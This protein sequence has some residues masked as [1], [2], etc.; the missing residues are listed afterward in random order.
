MM[1]LGLGLYRDLLTPETLRF[2]RQA[3]V[4]HIVA[5]LPGHFT[6]GADDVLTSDQ[7]GWGFGISDPDDPMWTFEALEALKRTVNDA[8]LVLE[9]LENFAPAHWYDVLLDGPRRAEQMEHLKTIVGALGRAGIPTMGYNF[10]LAGVWGRVEGPFA[11]AGA[12][13]VGFQDPVQPPIPSGMIWNMV[14]AP[15]RFDPD[16]P[17]Q[18]VA[19]VGHEEMWRRLAGF[20]R[21]MIPV[22]E[23]AGV[24]LALHPEDPPLPVL[25]GTA[26]LVYQ[27]DHFQRVL[28]LAPSAMNAIEFCVGTVSEMAAADVYAAVDRYSRAGRIA[29]VHLRN[30]KGKVPRYHET[31]VDE[32]DTDMLRVLKILHRIG[33]DGVVIPDHTPLLECAAPWHAG[34]AYALGWMRAAITAAERG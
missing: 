18:T 10:S 9:A 32:V 11:R 14:Y 8:G 23:A 15:E 28:D 33:F 21:E 2:A 17:N 6:R 22:A 31:F 5:H 27:P 30:V 24:R 29:Y 16:H 19:P 7:A 3:G 1:K 20:L 34:M 4:T 13:S 12:R 25:R 26:R